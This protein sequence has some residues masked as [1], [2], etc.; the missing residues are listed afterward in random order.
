MAQ[1][2]S[3]FN[4]QPMPDTTR[5]NF[6]ARAIAQGRQTVNHPIQG[7]SNLAHTGLLA[8]LVKQ[9]KEKERTRLTSRNKTVADA[10][11]AARGT[12]DTVSPVIAALADRTS[13]T[14]LDASG[15]GTGFSVTTPGTPGDL[16]AAADIFAKSDDTDL[17]NIGLNM[18]LADPKAR[19]TLTDAGGFNR[20]VDTGERVFPDAEAPPTATF[21]NVK[22][23][24]GFGGAGQVNSITGGITGYQAKP[25]ADKGD[26]VKGVPRDIFDAQPLAI[27]V[28]ILTGRAG[29]GEAPSLAEKRR[30][31]IA[32]ERALA[33]ASSFRRGEDGEFINNTFTGEPELDAEAF[34][35]NFN[36]LYAQGAGSAAQGGGLALSSGQN[37]PEGM[38][39]EQGGKT[40]VVENGQAVLF[41]GTA[42]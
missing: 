1:F 37:I 36:T 22:N 16:N 17:Q 19:E 15:G 33:M 4:D 6:L 29:K 21:E 14:S 35:R 38:T 28:D 42:P 13:G 10:F 18:L 8:A 5:N 11:A 12:P 20:F 25:T 39:F 2:R 9:Q 32:K 31:D 7:V 23:P 24:H 41:T 40:F 30:I 34:E 26:D 27:Q 3:F